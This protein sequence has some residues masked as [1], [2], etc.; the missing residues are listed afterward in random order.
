S[1]I[2]YSE[3]RSNFPK[4]S[5]IETKSYDCPLAGVAE[6]ASTSARPPPTPTAHARF[7]MVRP[8][9][10]PPQR[11]RARPVYSN[12][13]PVAPAP[14]KSARRGRRHRCA[15]TPRLPAVPAATRVPSVDTPDLGFQVR[16]HRSRP[17]ADCPKASAASPDTPPPLRSAPPSATSVYCLSLRP[18]GA[19]AAPTQ[20][21]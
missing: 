12:R 3:K 1:L 15:R 11:H 17:T 4:T 20:H 21:S 5:A 16:G 13:R 7:R 18:R 19:L 9:V 6:A 10:A 14:A 8:P 2:E